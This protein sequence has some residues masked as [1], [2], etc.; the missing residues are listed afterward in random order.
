MTQV[1]PQVYVKLTYSLFKFK[2]KYQRMPR[3]WDEVISTK[4]LDKLPP[5]PAGK[6]YAFDP[7]CTVYLK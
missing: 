3:D 1:D 5:A 6:H 4:F 2:E 7:S